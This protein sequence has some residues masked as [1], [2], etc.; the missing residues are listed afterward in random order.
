M[1]DLKGKTFDMALSPLG[2]EVDVSGAEAI[3]YKFATVARNV[4]S[5]FKLF[6][7]D[8]PGTP[9]KIGDSWPSSG[10]TEVKVGTLTMRL[11]IQNVN[12]FEGIE[13]VDGMECAHI[14]SRI[15]G[16]ISGSGSPM[17]KDITFSGTHKG[18]DLWFFAIK[19]G[20]YVQSTSE[21]TTK[22]FINV[23]S[24]GMTIPSTQM[25]KSEIKL[26]GKS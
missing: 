9:L 22:I 10:V 20:I 26:V 13:R 5:I 6:F 12:T 8:L 23:G 15:T 24:E 7:P 11:D 4:A 3:T 16:S 21:L 19:E 18:T 17:G 14:S 2:T 1:K 25:R